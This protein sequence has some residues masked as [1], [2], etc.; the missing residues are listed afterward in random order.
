MKANR[1]AL[2]II[3]ALL[4]FL[5]SVRN[6]GQGSSFS[7]S[8]PSYSAIF[9]VRT[10]DEYDA[11]HIKGSISLPIS[12]IFCNSC[13]QSTVESYYGKKVAIYCG[14][15]EKAGEVALKFF[16]QKG[17]DAF[18]LGDD[19]AG[20]LPFEETAGNQNY[21][22]GCVPLEH[23]DVEE[24]EVIP[25]SDSDELPSKWDW[26][27]ATYNN[28]TGDWTTP[29]KNQGSCGSCWDF[30]AMGALE[31]IINIRTNNPAMDVDLSEQ[32]LLSCPS[33]GGCSGWNAYWAYS[34]LLMHGGA[35]TEDCF[36]YEA[37]D[38]ILCSEKCPDWMN[39]LFPIVKYGAMRNRDRDEIKDMVVNFGP[40][41]AEMAVYGDFGS[42]TGGVYEHPGDEPVSDI[43]HQVVI[44]GYDDDQECW[45]VKNSWGSNWGE[46]GFFRIAYGDCQ[47]EHEIV[48]ADFSPTVARAGGPYFSTVGRQIQF[49]GGQ[50]RSYLSTIVSYSWDFGDG[51][52]GEGRMPLHAY[53]SE[54]KFVVHL[55]VTDAEGNQGVCKTYVYI[56]STPPSVEIQKPGRM[57]FYYF[58]DEGKFVPSL[59]TIVI[60]SI[61]VLASAS[62]NISGLEKV[63][64]YIDDTLVYETDE[65]YIKWD[66]NGPSFGFHVLEL[67]AYDT[68]GNVGTDKVRLFIWV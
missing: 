28:I 46:N 61:T 52:T 41:V 11:G 68:A 26:R 5:P 16:H 19:M 47:I 42:Y 35:I 37:N 25:L 8:S 40:V 29:V 51:T 17:I 43:N 3:I 49:D 39:H 2:C 21:A 59:R 30:A 10:P 12:K 1:I 65:G 9:D 15:N 55:T 6:E 13:M 58:N 44:V 54:G 45:I 53:S 64:M 18:I 67:K 60:G 36:P 23:Y 56:D 31:A 7:A 48:Y 57:R 27:D 34:Y 63:E 4:L 66:W 62:D 33:G 14:S 22:T 38:R 24:R 32:Y 50:S 20:R